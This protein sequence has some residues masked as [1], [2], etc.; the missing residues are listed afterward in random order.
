MCQAAGT[1]CAK[2]LGNEGRRKDSKPKRTKKRAAA[3]K[4]TSMEERQ[5]LLKLN[6]PPLP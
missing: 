3:S 6:H 1:I 2:V 4:Q 5:A